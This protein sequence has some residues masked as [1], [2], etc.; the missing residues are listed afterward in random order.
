MGGQYSTS[1]L[2]ESSSELSSSSQPV[3]IPTATLSTLRDIGG[4]SD[5][6]C[7]MCMKGPS[8]FV[9]GDSDSVTIGGA[10][11]QSET[12]KPLDGT[13]SRSFFQT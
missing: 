10:R 12:G 13:L 8:E 11:I 3:T 1:P 5:S 7:G 6:A 4:V 9:S 2:M